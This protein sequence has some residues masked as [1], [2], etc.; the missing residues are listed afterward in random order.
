MEVKYCD[1]HIASST[2]IIDTTNT[3]DFVYLLNGI[4]EGARPF[5]R[6]GDRATVR[7][8][9]LCISLRYLVNSAV[10]RIYALPVRMVVVYDSNPGAQPPTWDD[11][12]SGESNVGAAITGAF[13]PTNRRLGERF[14][15]L[16]D[17]WRSPPVCP[18]GVQLHNGSEVYVT[19]MIRDSIQLELPMRFR[20]S[21]LL[22]SD[23]ASGAIYLGFRGLSGEV[24]KWTVGGGCYARVIYTD[25]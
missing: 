1:R 4:G 13:A 17:E 20:S 16:Y 7:G 3:N 14:V 19:E 9:Q 5:E 24:I 12:F 22:T 11:M 21:G 18:T 25:G 10:A 23:I 15:L 2:W 6:I 8:L